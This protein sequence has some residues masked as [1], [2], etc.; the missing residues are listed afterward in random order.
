MNVTTDDLFKKIGL[1]AVEAD[2]LR[3]MN[4]ALTSERDAAKSALAAADAEV[5]KLKDEL[6]A[7][8]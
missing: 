2:T 1:L 3:A 6:A 4:A 5:T 7:K 8:G